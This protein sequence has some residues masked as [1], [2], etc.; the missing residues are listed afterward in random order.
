M[1]RNVALELLE[2]LHAARNQ[3]A[4]DAICTDQR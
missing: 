1:N 2:R 4:V 3:G